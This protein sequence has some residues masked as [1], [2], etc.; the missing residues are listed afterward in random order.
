MFGSRLSDF[1]S[2]KICSER[3]IQVE[4]S[5]RTRLHAVDFSRLVILLG[6]IQVKRWADVPRRFRFQAFFFS[7]IF[8]PS[9]LWRH[10]GRTR[11]QKA[12]SQTIF[13]WR[14]I[15]ADEMSNPQID[16]S[17]KHVSKESNGI[18]RC[19]TPH[20]SSK[21]TYTQ[22]IFAKSPPLVQSNSSNTLQDAGLIMRQRGV[23][24]KR[25]FRLCLCA[26]YKTHNRPKKR[27]SLTWPTIEFTVYPPPVS[28]SHSNIQCWWDSRILT[29][30]V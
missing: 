11:N 30:D 2:I 29:M 26:R 28:L 6:P 23:S 12:Y 27:A 8:E 7:T 19:D 4:R 22:Y 13:E 9:I 10:R 5:G 17:L 15:H 21:A 18:C 25:K 24:P 3:D 1:R 14:Y 16:I 20:H